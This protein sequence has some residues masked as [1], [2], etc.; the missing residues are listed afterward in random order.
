MTEL[1]SN[2]PAVPAR[3]AV[4]RSELLSYVWGLALAL[5]LTLA[6]F[7]LV[8]WQP[9]ERGTVLV[10]IG[11]LALVQMVVHFRFF[12]HIGLRRK[13]ED[14]LLILFSAVLLIVMV[15]GTIWIMSNLALRM[16]LPGVQ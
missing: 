11:V 6:A 4:A 2:P 5:L 1:D 15:A 13:R 3:E 7:A 10:V 16:A 12:L 8:R 14:L 9:W